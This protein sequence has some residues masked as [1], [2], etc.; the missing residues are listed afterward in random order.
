MSRCFDTCCWAKRRLGLANH[1]RR[2]GTFSACVLV[3]VTL[4]RMTGQGL[5]KW[6]DRPA[7]NQQ[8]VCGTCVSTLYTT[9]D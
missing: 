2:Q 8:A 6:V 9:F 7:N 4:S 1:S 5:L 3:P